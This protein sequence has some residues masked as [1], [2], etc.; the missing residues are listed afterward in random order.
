MYFFASANKMKCCAPSAPVS[1]EVALVEELD[2][3]ARPAEHLAVERGDVAAG[4]IVEAAGRERQLH[5]I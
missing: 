1:N 3:E 4:G 5:V 2:I